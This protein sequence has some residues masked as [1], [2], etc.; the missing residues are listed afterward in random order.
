MMHG[1]AIWKPGIG[2]IAKASTSGGGLIA[3]HM[4]TPPPTSKGQHADKC[5]VKTQSFMK[6]GGK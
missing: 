1:K 4:N 6:S 5:W 3:P 2:E